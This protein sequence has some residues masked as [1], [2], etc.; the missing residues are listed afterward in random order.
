MF[1]R[2][3]PVPGA[4]SDDGSMTTL[5]SLATN[6]LILVAFVGVVLVGLRVAQSIFG[7]GSKKAA[8]T[9]A[10]ARLVAYPTGSA[11]VLRRRFVKALTGQHVVMPSGDRVAF[12]ELVVRVS[13]EDLER[14][15]PDGDIDRLGEDAAKLYLTHAEREGWSTPEEVRVEVEVDPALRPGWVPPARG[16]RTGASVRRPLESSARPERQPVV[17]DWDVVADLTPTASTA[18][19]APTPLPARTDV[20]AAQETMAF[21]VLVPADAT[22]TVAGARDLF[23]HRGAHSVRVPRDGVTVLGRLPE[24]P[25]PLEEPEISYRHA[26]LRLLGGSWQ[27][28]DAG[29]TNGTSVDGE[30]I[31]D[32]WVT[33]RDGA[34]LAL[35]GIKVAVGSDTH[36]TVAVSGVSRR[37]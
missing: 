16:S 36:G 18:P 15:D 34:V 3:S 4:S 27:V 29:S 11:A 9:E 13:P 21:P 8:A 14:L 26:E 6:L 19:A 17:P 35:A 20:P 7:T 24:S 32:T 30:R 23:L 37:P 10:A 2:G 12:S 31:G 28:R 22:P 33:V 5:T 25:L 1:H